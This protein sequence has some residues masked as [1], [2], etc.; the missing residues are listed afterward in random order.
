MGYTRPS[1]F[2]PGTF[3]RTCDLCGIRYRANDL[4][5]GADGF[6]RCLKY[7]IEVPA[8]TRDR[9]SAQSQK[10]REAPPPPHGLPFDTADTYAEEA[11]V[12]DFL[13][14]SF[15][16]GI[17]GGAAPNTS[18]Q[19]NS[20]RPAFATN[21]FAYAPFLPTNASWRFTSYGETARYLYNLIIE[22]KRPAGWIS[23]AKTKLRALADAI[24]S[25]Q[26]GSPTFLQSSSWFWGFINVSQDRNFT[27][28]QAHM[29]LA[30][31]YAYL[32]LGDGKYLSGAYGVASYLRNA[33]ACGSHAISNFTSSDAGGTVRLYTGGVIDLFYPSVSNLHVFDASQFVVLE[34]WKL[35][36]ATSGDQAIGATGNGG[37]VF[38]S[39]PSQ[40]LSQSIADLRAFIA[41]GAFDV[42]S[43]TTLTGWSATTPRET[44]NAYPTGTGSWEYSDGN[45]SAGTSITGA[46]IA[47]ALRALFNYEGYSS[48]VS[49]IWTWLMGFASNPAFVSAAGTLAID[50]ACATT[51]KAA[52]PPA[53]PTGSGNIIA[54]FY[55]PTLALTTSLVVKGANANQNGSSLYDW[56][57]AGMLAGIQ[58]SRNS[59]KFR[60]A[61]RT[62]STPV[63]RMPVPFSDTANG[64]VIDYPMLRG[65][66]GLAMQLNFGDSGNAMYWNCIS[67]ARCGAVFRY[68]PQAWTGTNPPSLQPG[69]S[70]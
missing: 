59:S 16:S 50:Y 41:V 66:S 70:A 9:I 1:T 11:S 46:G 37:G 7:C 43:G 30:L 36:Y 32:A 51:T 24:L 13:A 27:A 10:R 19:V 64:P 56:S 3:L 38:T 68:Q 53:P 21:G 15:G 52:N 23:Q 4:R 33:Q 40:L 57:T 45:A 20:G 26:T 69:V 35:L 48:Q 34:L 22:G 5:K 31:L 55:D 17:T 58:S 47:M 14:G 44:F 65:V 54:P 42:F 61:K 28:A 18:W 8:I 12:I 63:L 60:I 49:T 2:V 6:W 39:A 29:G 67:A 62:M 25:S